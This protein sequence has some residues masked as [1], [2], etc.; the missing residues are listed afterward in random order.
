[1]AYEQQNYISPNSEGWALQ[2]KGVSRFGVWWEPTHSE[3]SSH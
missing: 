1:M 3:L 2:D